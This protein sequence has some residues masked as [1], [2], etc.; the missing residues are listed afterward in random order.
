MGMFVYESLSKAQ[1]ENYTTSATPNTEIEVFF[2]KPGT[3]NLNIGRLQVQ[4]KGAALTALSGIEY[5]IKKWTS[6]AGAGGTALVPSPSDPGAQACKAVAGIA[7]T[8]SAA[9]TAG[10]GGPVLQVMCGSGAAGPG[11]WVAA[12]ID[13]YKTLEG[14]ATQSMDLFSASGTASLLYEFQIG[15]YE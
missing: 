11:G 15:H 8:T 13:D 6:T 4:G 1:L 5:R 7:T 14:S 3:R 12:N 2:I 10:T 9:V